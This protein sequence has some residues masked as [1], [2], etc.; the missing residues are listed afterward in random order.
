MT[1]GGTYQTR[2]FSL[3]AGAEVLL[4]LDAD[5]LLITELGSDTIQVAINHGGESEGFKG[6]DLRGPITAARFRNAGGAAVAL[7]IATAKGLLATDRRLSV[8]GGTPVAIVAADALTDQADTSVGAGLTAQ[9]VAADT[10]RRT[11]MVQNLDASISIRIG[12]ST[13]GA[14]RGIEVAPG[15]VVT[16]DTSA[17]VHAHN[18]GGAAVDVAAVLL[19]A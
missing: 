2:S 1:P 18:P 16:L 14:A 3:A 11:I 7:T 8:A 19:S 17:A 13:V 12:A 6:L 10:A 15:D 4:D 9:I 5:Q